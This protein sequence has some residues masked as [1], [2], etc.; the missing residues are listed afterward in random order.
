[1][2]ERRMMIRRRRGMWR[3]RRILRR[4][5]MMWRS[6][7]WRMMLRML[8]GMILRRRSRPLTSCSAK[9]DILLL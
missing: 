9:E 3:T 4:R 2:K 8:W 7:M 6:R 5:R 1:M